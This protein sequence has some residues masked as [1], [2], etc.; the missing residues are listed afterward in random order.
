MDRLT[1]NDRHRIITSGL[2]RLLEEFEVLRRPVVDVS[3]ERTLH[4][5]AYNEDTVSEISVL[6]PDIQRQAYLSIGCRYL[7]LWLDDVAIYEGATKK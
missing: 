6:L 5:Y 4:I 3:D 7:S 2:Q 1:E